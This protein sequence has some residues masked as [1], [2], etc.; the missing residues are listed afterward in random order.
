MLHQGVPAT[1]VISRW[2]MRKIR[3]SVPVDIPTYLTLFIRVFLS[4]RFGCLLLTEQPQPTRKGHPFIM[5]APSLRFL[6]GWARGCRRNSCPFYTTVVY[7]VV[8]PALRK[9]RERRGTSRC[10]GF[11]SF[12]AGPPALHRGHVEAVRIKN[13]N[14][15]LAY[16]ITVFSVRKDDHPDSA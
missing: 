15:F 6:Q 7:A 16:S 2:D 10:G 11:C 1:Q 5:R 12:K 4:L 8:V 13:L 14:H 9:V 3:V